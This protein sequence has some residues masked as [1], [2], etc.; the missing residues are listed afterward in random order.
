LLANG[1]SQLFVALFVTLRT[2]LRFGA[3]LAHLRFEKKRG[4]RTVR[5]FPTRQE[6]LYQRE[7]GTNMRRLTAVFFSLLALS[8]AGTAAERLKFWNLTG[9]TVKELHLAPTGTTDWGPDQCRNDPD[10]AVDVDE[11][12]TLKDVVPGRYDVKLA[13]KKGRICVV[14]NVEVFAGKPYAFS[15]SEKDL[16]D[17]SE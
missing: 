4:L 14:R 10:G 3:I 8:L 17:C 7:P 12:L 6:N 5:F 1:I 2:L 9:F 11:R 15:I 13:D 16:T